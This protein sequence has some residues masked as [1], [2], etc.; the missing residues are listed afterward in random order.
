MRDPS[1]ALALD[2][3]VEAPQVL[4]EGGRG[5]VVGLS[6]PPMGWSAYSQSMSIPALDDAFVGLQ[7]TRAAASLAAQI[8]VLL[9]APTLAEWA[10]AAGES[11]SGVGLLLTRAVHQPAHDG[12]TRAGVSMLP[13]PKPC[14]A[15]G[16]SEGAHAVALR[17]PSAAEGAAALSA[18][19]KLHFHL[20]PAAAAALSA[21]AASL[22]QVARGP[23]AP[24]TAAARVPDGMG[25]E[26]NDLLLS[27]N[28]SRART[29]VLEHGCRARPQAADGATPRRLH[30]I[31]PPTDV[32]PRASACQVDDN[33]RA[34][35]E[36]LRT[37]AVGR[38][39]IAAVSNKNIHPM[40]W[41]YIEGLRRANISNSVVVALD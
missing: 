37:V 20:S 13:L 27:R 1:G 28:F 23:R 24:S 18:L 38:E 11:S 33:L 7:P 9:A 22:E 40:L 12:A 21:A 14:Y 5:Q 32:F 19:T 41:T 31:L 39:V 30:W 10:G 17:L 16:A 8:A 35:C 26:S 3:D 25:P 6:D 36:T 34:L 29:L 2:V 15:G 4:R